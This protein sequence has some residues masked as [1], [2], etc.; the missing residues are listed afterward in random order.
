[1][2]TANSLSNKQ[3]LDLIK[4]VNLSPAL[5]KS[6]DSILLA[7]DQYPEHLDSIFGKTEKTTDLDRVISLLKWN[8]KTERG[9]LEKAVYDKMVSA[10][11]GL[12]STMQLTPT[13]DSTF[14]RIGNIELP[15]SVSLQYRRRYNPVKEEA[16]VTTVYSSRH[17][18]R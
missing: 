10:Q 1:M 6:K 14:T 13:T 12:R 15:I 11:D 16:R 4:G 18:T 9:S 3:A 5:Q 8:R 2:S 7:E 17:R